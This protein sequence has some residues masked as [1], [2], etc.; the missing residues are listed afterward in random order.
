LAHQERLHHEERKADEA[1]RRMIRASAFV[2]GY[3]GCDQA[4]GEKV[5]A[6]EE[7]L[8]SSENDYDWLGT[9]I[10]FWENSARRA[11]NWAQILKRRSHRTP[12][13][14]HNPFVLGAI[15]DLGSCLD[16]L[17]AESISVVAE[18]YRWLRD[19]YEAIGSPMPENKSAE[20]ELV[21]RRLDCAV[22]NSV[23]FMREQ[24]GEPA[25]DSVRA[26][27]IEG[28]PIYECAGFHSRTHI[29]ICVR[30]PERI[31]GYFRPR[32]PIEASRDPN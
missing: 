4:I 22:I 20:G 3:H 15:I 26:P 7:H 13:Q 28:P 2:L 32:G 8:K 5:L 10:Y 12:T 9:G 14:I 23:H 31:L 1:L 21:I 25:F 17:E 16:L 24:E 29:Q 19:S 18:G 30:N 11:L 6:G 27:F